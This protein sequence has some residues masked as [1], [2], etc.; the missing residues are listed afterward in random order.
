VLDPG[1]LDAIAV[2]GARASG[3][4]LADVTR[5]TPQ[6]GVP[7]EVVTRVLATVAVADHDARPSTLPAGTAWISTDGRWALGPLHGQ[8][9]ADQVRYVGET[10]RA[11]HRARRLAELAE[12]LKMLAA[13]R[14]A[15]QERLRDAE[16]HRTQLDR[17]LDAFPP[18]TAVVLA[19]SAADV[20]AHHLDQARGRHAEA[21][22]HVQAAARAAATARDAL[23]R[24]AGEVGLGAHVD[25]L[26]A[27][28]D[29]T[30]AWRTDVLEALSAAAMLAERTRAHDQARQSWSDAQARAQRAANA[31]T[32]ADRDATEQHERAGTLRD[33][34]GTTRDDILGRVQTSRHRVTATKDER[35]TC[36]QALRQAVRRVG[37]TDSALDA[38][39][40]DHERVDGER[41]HAAGAF[42]AL[43]DV[44]LLGL[45]LGRAIGD[46]DRWPVRT[47]LA[48]A[49]EVLTLT[50]ELPRDE[51]ALDKAVER[52]KN[53][54]GRHQ[55]QMQRELVAGIRLFPRETGG[56]VVHDV[57]Y[58]GRTH[59]LDEL[60]TELREDVAEREA[61]LEQDEQRLL[62]RFL[63]G[64][65]HEHL[66]TRIRDA[67]DLVDRM[68]G[69]LTTCPTAAGQRVRLDWA[70]GEDAPPGTAQAIDL[71]LRGAHLLSDDH[72]AA[73]GS[74]LQQR[75]RQAREGDVAASL[76][77][78]LAGAFDYRRW[79]AFTIQIKQ[80]DSPNWRRLTRQSHGTG[81]GGEK[82]VMLHLPL[83]AAMAAHYAGAGTAPRLIV[84]DE[85]FAGI[86]RGTR[87]QL[88]GLLVSLDLDAVLTSHDE[89]GFY[90][91]LDGLSTYHLVRDPDVPGVLA[92]WFVW[93]G[94]TRWD[95]TT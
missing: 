23:H 38:A 5:P 4:T 53:R 25:R 91:E 63:E 90:G 29:A 30:D 79:F 12:H 88:M 13:G 41:A 52:A 78:R 35:S 17:E 68:N 48:H 60:I 27:L 58:Q 56:V 33:M 55:Q 73:L 36:E 61:R 93:D 26:D 94:A 71:L 51:D 69:Q 18:A 14:S 85:V 89:W 39:R 72:R 57:Q 9:H 37:E 31:A 6:G 84:L 32:M 22:A 65:L 15:A 8:A 7:A 62:Q 3:R 34:V 67:R 16:G 77:E 80:G 50:G 1:T 45:V 11:S 66:R 54:L 10:A 28:A 82:A 21:D 49:R 75:L 70:V 19:R 42:R 92:E 43:G 20:A 87:G 24:I 44:G 40:G 95:M 76:S 46:A 81:S 86:D 83:F 59:R 74:Y 47:A 2:A 64:E